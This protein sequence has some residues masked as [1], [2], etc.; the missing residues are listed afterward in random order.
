MKKYLYPKTFMIAVFL[1]I[2]FGLS[3]V[4]LEYI[5]IYKD[6]YSLLD[7]LV[8]HLSTYALVH[9]VLYTIAIF[10]FA[11]ITA[12]SVKWREAIAEAERQIS[13]RLTHLLASSPTII[14]AV[15]VEGNSLVPSYISE[16]VTRLLGFTI[17]EAM[18][19]TWW[20]THVHSADREHVFANMSTL[21][22]DGYLKH[23]YRFVREDDTIVWVHDE[24]R[25]LRDG[26]GRPIE[27]VGYWIDITE[28]KRAEA[29]LLDS[30]EDLSRLL[31][32]IAEGAYGVDINGNCT[33]VNRSFLQILGYRN[34]H[35]VL[36]KHMHE[37]IH[38]SHYDGSPY[39]SSECR[40]Y[41]AYRSNQLV[42]VS[43]EVFWRKDG[44]AVPVE[45][46]S[47]PIVKN[48][49]VIGAIATFIDITKRKRAEEALQK[50]EELFRSV[51]QSATDAI[52]V[53]I[54]EDNIVSWN[55]AAQTIF[56]YGEEEALGKSLTFLMPERFHD[57]HRR[58]L[59]RFL[60]TG[61]S[62][63]VGKTVELVGR[64]KDGN[65]FPLELSLAS[66][67]TSEKTFFTGII[68]DI[69]ER[70]QAEQ[71]LLDLKTAVEQSVEGI[72]KA[73]MEGNIVFANPAWARMHGYDI[74]E[75]TCKHLS[76][77][78]TKEQVERD[79]IPFNKIVEEHGSHAGEVGHVRKDGSTFLTW[80]S[81][82]IIKD[83]R[84]NPVGMIGAAIDITERKQAEAERE[85]LITE[86]QQTLDKVKLLSGLL[87]ICANCKKIRDDKGYWSQVEVYMIEHTD[88]KFSHGICPDCVEKYWKPQLE[89]LK[90]A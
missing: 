33:F 75:I 82:T 21:F 36:G 9:W 29:T 55:N 90:K 43:D 57:S 45:Y 60:S 14:Y 15:R 22:V 3:D 72:A 4:L 25:L 70:K 79:V 61:K 66:W 87:P 32:S 81:T 30:R 27:A 13:T 47:H 68:R 35:E 88:A 40:M 83:E 86:L 52:I 18:E 24:L 65:E 77:F 74:S 50:S 19:P 89:Q 31:D 76:I 12:Q 73:D 84:N 53:A 17:H 1:S 56:D 6:R 20:G 16:S 41:R 54:S 48:G 64:K 80:M 7:I 44:V 37:L 71:K 5:A 63:V 67:K 11:F 58:G 8:L 39:S 38:H 42:N 62:V 2:F 78:H 28:R 51:A 49:V 23:E 10:I 85:K 34:D 46:W 26:S 59:R 69:T